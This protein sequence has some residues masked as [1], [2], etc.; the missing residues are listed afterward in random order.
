M[1]KR[2]VILVLDHAAAALD[3]A[4]QSKVLDGILA[5]R[6]GQGVIWALQRPEF[7]ERFGTVLVIDHGR[8][9]EQGRFE[10]LKANGGPLNKMLAVA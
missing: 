1:V 3:P 8:L 4:S 6:K 9:A 5:E 10:T 7:A 2:P